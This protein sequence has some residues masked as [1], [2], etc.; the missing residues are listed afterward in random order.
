M[1]SM[2]ITEL[3]VGLV[4]RIS[5]IEYRSAKSEL[6]EWKQQTKLAAV[7]NIN[8]IHTLSLASLNKR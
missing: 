4:Y 6:N 3:S 1:G 5:N 8:E 2:I 7:A